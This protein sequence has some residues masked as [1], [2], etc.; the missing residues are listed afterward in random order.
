[1]SF[2]LSI[3]TF[4]CINTVHIITQYKI[5]K[6]WYSSYFKLIIWTISS[7]FHRVLYTYHYIFF[8]LYYE[9]KLLFSGSVIFN[10]FL[11]T[12]TSSWLHWRTGVTW[13]P[14]HH[15]H[16]NLHQIVKKLMLFI[17]LGVLNAYSLYCSRYIF[18]RCWQGIC[19]AVKSYLSLLS[20]PLFL[21]L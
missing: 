1:M 5:F 17:I 12:T 10:W 6:F 14:R 8:N 2:S 9:L 19:L 11:N 15:S 13:S 18:L 16:Q 7:S 20:L 21:N 4:L 3:Y